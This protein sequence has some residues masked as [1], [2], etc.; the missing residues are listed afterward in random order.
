MALAHAMRVVLAGTL[1]F[2]ALSGAR[3][4]QTNKDPNFP[5][6]QGDVALAPNADN[7]TRITWYYGNGVVENQPSVTVAYGNTFRQMSYIGYNEEGAWVSGQDARNRN[8]TYTIKGNTLT[9]QPVKVQLPL[10]LKNGAADYLA[11]IGNNRRKEAKAAPAQQTGAAD[12]DPNFPTAQGDVALAPNGDNATRIIWYYSTGVVEDQ[13]SV[14]VA[15]G[16]TNRKMSYIG[17]NEEGAWV[18]GQDARNRNVTYTIKGNTLTRQPV[19]VQLPMNLKNG[20]AYYREWVG[21]RARKDSGSADNP[22]QPGGNPSADTRGRGRIPVITNGAS[23]P[24]AAAPGTTTG[25]DVRIERGASG[26][27]LHYKDASGEHSYKVRRPATASPGVDNV[28]AGGWVYVAPDG[29]SGL[30]LNVSPNHSVSV[31]P[32]VQPMLGMLAGH[33]AN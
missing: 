6:A 8:V 28:D 31:M 29:K 14:M 20:A 23:R 4:Q 17:Y 7:A 25:T 1:A 15:Y 10:N 3:G 24:A 2:G 33:T 13:P 26:T 27:T 32:L 12:S 5:T 11:Y 18:S 21:S 30:L 16:P 22:P 19:N 9:R